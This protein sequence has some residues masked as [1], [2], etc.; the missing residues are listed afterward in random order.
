MLCHPRIIKKC[1]LIGVNPEI[2]ELLY[3]SNVWPKDVRFLRFNFKFGR[4]FSQ[5]NREEKG[6]AYNTNNNKES[7]T[8]LVA[9]LNL[10]PCCHHSKKTCMEGTKQPLRSLDIAHVNVRS[11]MSSFSRFEELVC[12]NEFDIIGITETWLTPVVPS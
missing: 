10:T 8:K 4:H 11:L 7:R 5:C 3:D 2:K 9:P 1:F 6:L 12:D